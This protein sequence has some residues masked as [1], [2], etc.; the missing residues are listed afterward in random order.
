MLEAAIRRTALLYRDRDTW[1]R[2]RRNGMSTDVSWRNPARRY[3]QLY[4]S[5]LA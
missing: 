1:S 2:V 5:V 4:R 3:A